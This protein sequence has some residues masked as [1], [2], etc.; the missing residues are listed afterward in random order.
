MKK[1]FVFFYLP[2]R[3]LLKC[4]RD[5]IETSIVGL[6]HRANVRS[7]LGYNLFIYLFIEKFIDILNKTVRLLQITSLGRF[8]RSESNSE[9]SMFVLEGKFCNNFKV[10]FF[11]Y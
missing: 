3:K 6:H 2:R 11:D 1:L 5:A 9:T 4:L 10:F 7:Y 8:N